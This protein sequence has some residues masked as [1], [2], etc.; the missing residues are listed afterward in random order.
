MM[1][2]YSLWF[3]LLVLPVTFLTMYARYMLDAHTVSATIAGFLVGAII[4][5]LFSTKYPGFNARVRR[6]VKRQQD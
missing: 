6:L 4:T 5:A 2:R 3:G 1:R